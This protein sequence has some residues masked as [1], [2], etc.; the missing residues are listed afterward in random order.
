MDSL[1]TNCSKILHGYQPKGSQGNT[2]DSKAEPGTDFKEQQHDKFVVDR[3][4]I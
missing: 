3:M 4:K 1:I 2:R